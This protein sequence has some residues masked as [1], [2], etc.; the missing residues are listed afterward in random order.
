M[1]VWVLKWTIEIKSLGGSLKCIESMCT[2]EQDLKKN[3]PVQRSE[4]CLS[5]ARLRKLWVLQQHGIEQGLAM[6]SDRSIS[7]IVCSPVMIIRFT[8]WNVYLLQ[9]KLSIQQMVASLW[10][11]I[12]EGSVSYHVY[13]QSLLLSKQLLNSVLWSCFPLFFMLGFPSFFML[14]GSLGWVFFV[15]TWNH[16]VHLTTDLSKSLQVGLKY[17]E[18]LHSLE[19]DLHHKV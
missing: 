14:C 8:H 18:I 16:P 19:A 6:L 9:S 17:W 3:G 5:L 4:V 15:Q 2:L 10:R 7:T 13:D 1:I 12:Q 11:H